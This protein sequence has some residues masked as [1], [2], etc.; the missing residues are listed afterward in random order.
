[1]SRVITTFARY[2]AAVI[3]ACGTSAAIFFSVSFG[4]MFV[5]IVSRG[6]F[7]SFYQY[8]MFAVFPV[9]GF[10]GVFAGS[11]CLERASRRFGSIFLLILGLAYYVHWAY[12][13]KYREGENE[14]H[15]YGWLWGLAALALGGV[16]A[17]IFVF[18]RS[19]SNT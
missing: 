3:V 8:L 18:R 12:F 9:M 2:A 14:A 11:F 1:M 19:S 15:P 10:C 16:V 17:L 6:M 4:F 7:D 13:I 5:S